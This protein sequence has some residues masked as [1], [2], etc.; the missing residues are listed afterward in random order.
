MVIGGDRAWLTTAAPGRVRLPV[1]L[2]VAAAALAGLYLGRATDQPAPPSMIEGQTSVPAI[3]RIFG[4]CMGVNGQEALER[5][6]GAG[7]RFRAGHPNGGEAWV[8][9]STSICTDGFAMVG[10]GYCLESLT[11][12]E[13][14]AD[15][16]QAPTIGPLPAGHG[17]LGAIELGASRRQ[18]R[19]LTKSLGPPNRRDANTWEWR[20]TGYS[21][22]G[23]SEVMGQY[24]YW[25]A[26]LTFSGDCLVRIDLDC[27]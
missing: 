22:P 5:V 17:W 26:A 14:Q 12:E 13:Q 24:R 23:H 21:H 18:V 20:A 11:W 10:E 25:R 16:S 7:K 8:L 6:W 9:G 27:G 4:V 2:A 1:L 15:R 19:R 3:A